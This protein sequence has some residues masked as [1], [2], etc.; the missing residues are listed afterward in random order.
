MITKK[1]IKEKIKKYDINLFEDEIIK[2]KELIFNEILNGSLF[3]E[4]KY[5]LLIM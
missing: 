4:K 2:K 5:F 3:E 1:I